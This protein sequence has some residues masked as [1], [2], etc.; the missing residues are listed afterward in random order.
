VGVIFSPRA[1]YADV[2]ARPRVA[3]VLLLV[4]VIV[5]TA[6]AVFLSTAVGKEALLDQQIRAVESFGRQ[7]SDEQYARMERL[8][9][10]GV[11]VTS[12]VQA[13]AI[14]LVSLISAGVLLAV[15]NGALGG[16]ASFKQVLGVVAHSQVLV[17]LDRLFV[18]PLDYA[19][20]SISSP[21]TLSVFL[22]M[23]DD[24]SLSAHILGS[25]DLFWI[26]VIVNLSIGLGVLY[27]KRTAPVAMSLLGIYIAGAL[28]YA[29]VRTAL[30]GT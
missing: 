29:A 4:V 18:L 20:G 23:L 26:W 17:A 5:V 25:I 6:S 8:V 2:A 7:V 3:G 15:F 9:Q 12:V 19:K 30:A 22:P 24:T 11:Y 27:K 21:T 10:A 14:P 1:T 16:N 28:V 13:A